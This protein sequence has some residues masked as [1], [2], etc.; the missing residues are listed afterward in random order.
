M[1]RRFGSL[2]GP[3]LGEVC[4][5]EFFF[6]DKSNYQLA[7]VMMI[8]VMEGWCF[9]ILLERLCYVALFIILLKIRG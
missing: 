4:E 6:P 9:E 5:C 2:A 7:R 1:N 8:M 3:N